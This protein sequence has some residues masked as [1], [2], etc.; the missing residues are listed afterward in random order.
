MSAINNKTVKIILMIFL[1]IIVNFIILKFINIDFKLET[2]MIFEASAEK[3]CTFQV[4]Y[5]SQEEEWSEENSIKIEYAEAGKIQKFNI[6]INDNTSAVRIDTGDFE[7][8]IIIKDL[9]ISK[10]RSYVTLW[11]KLNY[12][13]LNDKVK[14]SDISDYSVNDDEISFA[15]IGADPYFVVDFNEL[16]LSVF[17]GIND[18]C[19][20]V[21]RWLL[22]VI[23]SVMVILI[24]LKL[25]FAVSVF[26]EIYISKKLIWSLSVNDFKTKYA[27]SFFGIVWAFVQP[28]ITIVLYWFVFQV[29]FRSTDVGDCP[30]VLWLMCGLVPWFFFS[31]GI[32]NATNSM[33]EYSYLVKKVVFRISILPIVKIISAL[34]VHLFFM[35]F[36]VVVFLCYKYY[37]DV[38]TLQIFYYTF[39]MFVLILGLS[40]AACAMVIFFRDLGQI[41]NILLQIF[42]WVT[43]IMWNYTMLGERQ[44]LFLSL[45]PYTI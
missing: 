12:N 28:V 45:T 36:T 11:D 24:S 35:M 18:S 3:P 26:K 13:N 31:D 30:F 23:A 37:P 1:L 2:E 42:M 7:N 21:L 15:A 34:F 8:N 39:S 29:G 14:C 20:N 33:L 41:I 43:P 25:K 22:C 40:Y 32:I 27:G 6:N 44:F 4:F 38:Y 19:N 17:N 10:G 5:K 9:I 16:D